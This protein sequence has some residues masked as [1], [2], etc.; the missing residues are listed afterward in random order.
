MDFE[1]IARDIWADFDE[2]VSIDRIYE[3]N[4]HERAVT[5][6]KVSVACVHQVYMLLDKL[7]KLPPDEREECISQSYKYWRNIYEELLKL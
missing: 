6:K 3:V 5:A 7:D 1:A 4:L 2:L